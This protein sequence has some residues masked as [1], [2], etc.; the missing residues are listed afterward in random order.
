VTSGVESKPGKKDPGKLRA[1]FDQV[2]RANQQL[3][4]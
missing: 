3:C 2:A 1:F 4:L